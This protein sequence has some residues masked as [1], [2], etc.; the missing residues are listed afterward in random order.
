MKQRILILG[1][2]GMLGRSLYNFFCKDTSCSVY[3]T[4]RRPNYEN[5]LIIL[6]EKLFQMLMHLILRTSKN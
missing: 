4:V 1:V 6:L 2:T 5:T 3:G